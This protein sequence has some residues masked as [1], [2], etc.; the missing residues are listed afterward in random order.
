M[1][2]RYSYPKLYG[3]ALAIGT[4]ATVLAL[5]PGCRRPADPDHWFREARAQLDAGHPDRADAAVRALGRLRPP[6]PFDRL[7]RAQIAEARHLPDEALGELS[8]VRDDHPLAPVSRLLAGQIEAKR[9]KLRAAEAQL[10]KAVAL[11][12][13]AVQAHRELSYIYNVQQRQADLD[14]ELYTLSELNALTF[15]QLVHWGKTRNVVWNPTRDVETLTKVVAADPDDRRSRLALAEGLRRLN[16]Q[17][18]SESVLSALPEADPDARAIR[19]LIALDR[20]DAPAVDRLLGE[21]PADHPALAKI[22]GQLALTRGDTGAAV[23]NLKRA[24]EGNPF[25][26]SVLQSLGNA[27]RTSGDPA[28]AEPYFA[29]ARLHDALTPLISQASSPP[30]SNDPA[31]PARLGAA[32][33]AAGRLFEARAWY[34]IAV[35]K[36]PLDRQA[37][38]AVF[39]LGRSIDARSADRHASARVVET[40]RT[41]Q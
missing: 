35:A 9:F 37:Q 22:R 8:R 26:R 31:L 33:E 32:C 4:V 36:D 1:M 14:A 2:D 28:A 3:V 15:D 27:L 7:L 30:G 18:E 24:H 23:A 20:G 38:Q 17:D 34:K 21:G 16:K 41:G 19:A 29:A 13:R 12:P 40:G 10:L 39:R 11:E 5:V 25:D 6:N